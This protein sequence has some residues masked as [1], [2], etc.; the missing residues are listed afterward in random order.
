MEDHHCKT[1][2]PSLDVDE[3]RSG[4]AEVLPWAAPTSTGGGGRMT[5]NGARSKSNKHA[6][7]RI[8]IP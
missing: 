1:Q 8:Q 2:N 7:V 4:L 3:I 5:E 6:S